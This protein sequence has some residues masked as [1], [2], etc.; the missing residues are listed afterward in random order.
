MN[1]L[2]N[3]VAL[4][5]GSTSGIGRGILEH[6]A[7]CGARVVV[8]GRDTA[9]ADAIVTRLR[10]AGRVAASVTGNLADV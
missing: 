6:F 2:E 10:A 4:V 1:T 8:H 7:A 9:Q 3:K 5:T